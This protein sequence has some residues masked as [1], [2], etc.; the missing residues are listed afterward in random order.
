MRVVDENKEEFHMKLN[1]FGTSRAP[2][3]PKVRV[4]RGIGSGLR[5]TGGRGVKGQNSRPASP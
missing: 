3:R 4:G 2:T 1:G 5:K